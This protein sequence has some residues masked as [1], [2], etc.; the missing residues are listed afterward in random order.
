MRRP[1]IGNDTP[2]AASSDAAR[3]HDRMARVVAHIEAS[4]E[5]GETA[6]DLDAL[7]DIAC[8]SRFHFHR[9]YR[10]VIGETPAQTVKRLRLH[11][12]AVALLETDRPVAE[13]AAEAGYSGVDAFTRAFAAAHRR[14]PGAFRAAPRELET[15]MSSITLRDEPERRL[16]AFFH[17]G[18]YHQIGG[19]FE[20]LYL[21]AQAEG[22]VGAH[23]KM[24][25]I[26]YDD[27][28]ATPEAELRSDAALVVPAEWTPSDAAPA[29]ATTLAGGPTAVCLHVGPYAELPQ[30]WERVYRDWL[31]QSGR[32][33]ADAPTYEIYL[34]DPMSTPPTE[35]ATE[36][37][38]PLKPV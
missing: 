37:C 35:L 12:A 1:T 34:N 30:A 26:Y 10:A 6:L 11:R 3:Y 27:P 4:L 22:L 33:P 13:I 21:W 5:A 25:G 28:S 17:R 20:R 38:V 2:R 14:A 19:A 24:I 8:F 18:A 23:T 16:A 29:H 32:E 9:L 7:A 15:L 31:P 36:I